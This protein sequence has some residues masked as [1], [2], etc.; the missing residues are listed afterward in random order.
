MNGR[1]GRK[2]GQR[3]G[4]NRAHF[5]V[6]GGVAAVRAALAARPAAL[7][8]LLLR[9]DVAPGFGDVLSEM[10]AARLPY[11][12]VEGEELDRAA[13]SDRH[14]GVV[15]T[16]TARPRL[17]DADVLAG[18]QRRGPGG[19]PRLWL[20]LDGV[21]NPHN[22]GAIARTAAHFGVDLLLQAGR[23]GAAAASAAAYRVAEGGL[24]SVP[25]ATLADPVAT[26]RAAREVAGLRLI[27]TA[28]DAPIELLGGGDTAA[29]RL[30]SLGL[31]RPVCWLLGEERDGLRPEIAA[32]CDA[33]VRISG[34]GAVE[35]LNVASTAAILLAETRRRR[36]QSSV[37]R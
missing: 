24:E 11:R 37:A 1:D 22:L 9:A 21:G 27:G 3:G 2:G 4:R 34:T 29:S 8:R 17:A 35:S 12:V 19:A 13:G 6:I 30:A 16:F 23:Q 7:R 18:V 31:E 36:L 25:L 28:A 14:Q 5:D 26:L 33:N 10:A 20:Y 32:L 15:A